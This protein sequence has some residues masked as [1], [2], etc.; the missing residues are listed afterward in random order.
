MLTLQG[1]CSKNTEEQKGEGLQKK[2]TQTERQET[3]DTYMCCV[4]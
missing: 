1:M 2:K 3:G 4:N